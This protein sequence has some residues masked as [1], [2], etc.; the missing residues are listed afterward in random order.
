M[1]VSGL[2]LIKEWVFDVATGVNAQLPNVP[3]SPG[4]DPPPA[5]NYFDVLAHEWVAQGVIDRDALLEAGNPKAALI[6][7]VAEPE[8]GFSS[9]V[10]PEY[11][12]DDPTVIAFGL[13][14]VARKLQA[15]ASPAN[16]QTMKRNA[17]ESIRT[18]HRI[19]AQKFD[20]AHTAFSKN[21][22]EFMLAKSGLI[23]NTEFVEVKDDAIYAALII[24]LTVVDRW[25]LGIDP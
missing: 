15:K 1:I 2:E 22:C 20:S 25:A 24:P 17:L 21:Q 10:L 19:V 11:L 6:L 8:K 13:S 18:A 9:H 3:R 23:L 4:I 5:V 16:Y 7:D 12:A 14:Y